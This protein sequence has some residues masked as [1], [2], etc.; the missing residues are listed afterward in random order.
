[1]AQW[2][3]FSISI[4]LICLLEFIFWFYCALSAAGAAEEMYMVKGIETFK[5][6]PGAGGHQRDEAV[7]HSNAQEA[8]SLVE[9][10]YD[11]H[12]DEADV[13]Q[14]ELG[15]FANTSIDGHNAVGR[16]G[17][18]IAVAVGLLSFKWLFPHFVQKAQELLAHPFELYQMLKFKFAYKVPEFPKNLSEADIFSYQKLPEVSRSFAAVIAELPEELRRPIANFCLVLRGLDTV[19]DDM[20]I[21]LEKKMPELRN[22]YK[23]LYEKGWKVSGYGD[24]KDERDLLER[25]H[26][27]IDVF[28][29]LK[30]AYQKVIADVTRRMGEGMAKYAGEKTVVTLDDY[31]EYCHYVAGL[32]GIGLSQ[33]FA[34]SGL[35]SEKFGHMDELANSMGLF[36]QKTNVTR[37]YLE[38]V[39]AVSPRIFY[40]KDIWGKYAKSIGDLKEPENK[41]TALQCLNEMVTN[42]M[43]HINDSLDYM[44]L[45][46]HPNVFKF[47]CIPQAMAIAT[48]ARIYNNYDVFKKAVKIRKGEA[49]QIMMYGGDYETIISYFVKYIKEMEDKIPAEDPNTEK[50]R[51]F[52]AVARERIAKGRGRQQ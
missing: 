14:H 47:C 7:R 52:I 2:R 39:T 10:T 20:S 46:S 21:P 4:F 28:L 29:N 30:P 44:T 25:F 23:H 17:V 34:A 12:F 11:N 36:L 16:F 37:D 48:L 3:Q 13:H 26:F 33:M 35:E 42:A 40:P 49:V 51:H 6:F 19:E 22:F 1:M 38:D 45:L 18:W 5:Q 9:R 32:V 8:A 41:E 31:N 50:M 24:N 27:V 43:T 15:L